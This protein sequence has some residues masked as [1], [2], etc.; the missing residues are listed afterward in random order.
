M[1][2]SSPRQPQNQAFHRN[3]EP[4]RVEV[5][6]LRPSPLPHHRT[7]E[8]PSECNEPPQQPWQSHL[9]N[10]LFLQPTV[11]FIS[12]FTQRTSIFF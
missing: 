4:N 7:C 9:I 10:L 8:I 11:V 5:T 6:G 2:T 3:Q 12:I 1:A